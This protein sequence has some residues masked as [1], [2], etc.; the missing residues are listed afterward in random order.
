MYRGLKLV[1]MMCQCLSNTKRHVQRSP[2][3]D[4]V[5]LGQGQRVLDIRQPRDPVPERSRLGYGLGNQGRGPHRSVVARRRQHR[6]GRFPPCIDV[7]S[8]L[9]G[10]RDSQR[11]QQ[12]VGNLDLPGHGRVA[13]AARSRLAASASAF[14]EFA[15]TAT[16]CSRVYAV[17]L[18]AA[19]RARR[20]GGPTLIENVTYRGGAHSTSDDPTKYRPKDEWDAFPLGD[21]VE[22][23]KQHLIQPRATGRRKSTRSSRKNAQGRSDCRLEGGADSTER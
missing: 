3:A 18:W 13:N 20:G 19:D 5:S 15:S 17:T 21:P 22:R 16:T 8:G 11:R 1:D 6:R 14:P 12:P 10:A 2:V 9:P 4:H 7:R 23:L